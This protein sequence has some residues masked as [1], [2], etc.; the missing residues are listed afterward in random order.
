MV[1]IIITNKLARYQSP[2][3]HHHQQFGEIWRYKLY[4][5]HH[6]AVASMLAD[7][8]I[9]TECARLAYMKSAWQVHNT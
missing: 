5:I 2:G 7:M 3:I 6:Q 8:A 1:C 9:N 4:T